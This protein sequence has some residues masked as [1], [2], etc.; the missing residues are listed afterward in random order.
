MAGLII[1]QWSSLFDFFVSVLP[2]TD[3]ILDRT[4][5]VNNTVSNINYSISL[6]YRKCCAVRK[7]SGPESLSITN[8]F[9]V[10]VRECV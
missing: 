2:H 5:L 6:I 3:D 9:L 1:R 4:I 8:G 10:T 7:S